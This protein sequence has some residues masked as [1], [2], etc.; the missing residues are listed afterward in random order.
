M[1]HSIQFQKNS[2]FVN[3]RRAGRIEWSK[4]ART[5]RHTDLE[6]LL[7]ER[8]EKLKQSEENSRLILQS[9]A[10]GIF[11]TDAQGRC[12]FVNEAA[13]KMLGYAAEEILGQSIHD[14]FHHS[15]PDGAPHP[16]QECPIY[17]AYTEGITRFRRDEV[18]WRKD[19]SCFDV[20][21][22]SVPQRKEATIV[23]AVVVFRDI[24]ERKKGED[25][26]Q[27]S[28][29]RLQTILTTSN[30]GFWWVNNDAVTLSVNDAMCHILGRPREQ[31]L[32]RKIHEFLDAE[33]RII[34]EDQLRRRAAGE[35]GVYEIAVCRPDGASVTCLFHATPFCDKNGIKTGSFAMVTDIVD[36]KR[37]EEALIEARNKAESA[38][39]AK[40]DFLA[41]MSHEIRTPM[42]AILGMTHLALKTDLAPRQR[43][44]LNKIQLSANSLL[45][46]INDILDFSR[47]EAG[48]LNM[49]FIGFNLDEVL[50]NL[51]A[52]MTIKTQE[53]EGIEI[54]F[55]TDASVP[56]S[57][58]GDP[59]RLGQVLVNLANNAVKFTDHGEIV[60]ST[61]LLDLDNRRAELRFAVRDTG[62]GMT[63]DQISHLF[64]P[65]SQADT[66]ITRKYGGTGLGLSISQRLVEMMGGRIWVESVPDV[67]ST[68]FFTAFFEIGESES[69]L[70]RLPPPNLRGIRALVVD[71]SPTSRDIFQKML[72]S[73]TFQ[74]TLADS[75]EAGLKEIEKSLAGPSYDIVVMDWKMPD[76]DGFEA[77]RRIKHDPRLSR[78]PVVILVSAYGREEILWRAESAG[79]DAFLIKPIS[80][81][82]MFDTILQALTKT[83]YRE[84]TGFFERKEAPP[85]KM[86]GLEG[87]RILLVEDNELNQQ[88]AMEILAG[89]GVI[90]T[91]AGNGQE[92]LNAAASHSFDAVLMD[93]QMPVMDGYT[94]TRMLRQDPRLKDMPIIAMTAHAMSGDQ[95]KSAAAGMNDH[96]PKPIDP[97]RLFAV[98]S[99][100]ITATRHTDA[101]E[102]RSR[103]A[104]ASSAGGDAPALA[105]TAL[106]PTALEEFD[107]MDGLQRLGG[108]QTLY[109]KLLTDFAARYN[110]TASDVAQAIAAGDYQKSR[111]I[112]HDVKG[113]AGNLGAPALQSAASELEKRLKHADENLSSEAVS[114]ELSVFESRLNRAVE[115]ARSLTPLTPAASQ[116][117]LPVEVSEQTPALSREMIERL[118][119]AAEMGDISGLKAIAAEMGSGSKEFVC[120][121]DRIV[122]MADD[123]DFDGI[124]KLAGI[125][126]DSSPG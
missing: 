24:T 93:I 29:Y 21:Y 49:E 109:R 94:A 58:V 25:A 1:R 105:D 88:V 110:R 75:G 44:Y 119:D 83:P 16:P 14:L 4:T 45:G 66:S 98:L 31:I 55:N 32:G 78:L 15:N 122:R 113:L 36:R 13:Q 99:R 97:P 19:G 27:E 124:L 114:A 76:M 70:C 54:L 26:L 6:R 43:D 65:F 79:L 91:L 89:A 67:G 7:A 42:N 50:D 71:D 103:A 28:E 10:E 9:A 85:D 100:W 117:V 59:L 2:V 112:V 104:I 69:R 53:K 57:L 33:N 63:E 39:K 126:G 46:I 64:T 115:S 30:E 125:S 41:N 72:E 23:G 22:T 60:V 5:S 38:T 17:L 77:A 107:L 92:A 51:A 87:V 84:T 48:K 73:F 37:M 81:S 35:T 8:T 121:A 101:P 68:F 52:M 47:I 62:I 34:I 56:R 74:V 106:F 86:A 108:N 82:V 40:G 118:H 61:E 111:Q 12:T 20:S 90:V 80:P 3:D 116:V 96:I 102:D 11:G 120:Y 123:F 18:F 95:E